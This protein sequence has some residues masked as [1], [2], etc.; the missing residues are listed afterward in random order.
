MTEPAPDLDQFAGGIAGIVAGAS[1]G[2]WS[3]DA[4]YADS[5]VGIVIGDLP[6][7]PSQGIALDP[8][9]ISD[10]PTL[11]D[12]ILAI[13]VRCRGDLDPRTVLRRD[14]AIFDRLQGLAA[15]AFGDVY[16]VV[17]WRQSNSPLVRDANRRWESS[18]TYYARV[19]WPSR[20]RPD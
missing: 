14:A 20:H 8:Y 16:V 7:T 11:D 1:I 4:A 15:I 18:S 5:D 19:N 12:S 2:T 6:E 13:E 10:D 17:M 9:V 3:P